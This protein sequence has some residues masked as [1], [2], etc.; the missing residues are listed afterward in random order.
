MGKDFGAILEQWEEQQAQAKKVQKGNQKSHKK[1]NAPTK[2]EKEAMQQGY[3]YEQQMQADN[4]CCANP[5]EVWLNRYG[6]V[7][8]DK[9]ADEA[10]EDALLHNPEYLKQ[11]R[12]EA[13]LDLHGLTR[14]DAWQRLGSFIDD[15][16]R[17]GFRKVTIIHG[18]GNHSHGT[19]PVLGPMVKLFIEQDKRL[20]RSGHPDRNNGGTGATWVLFK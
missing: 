17:R 4:A 13:T 19:D 14:D 7:D 9:I 3:S 5:L 15:C 16:E 10:R 20:G 2:E 12:S 8:K 1:A 11:L 6:T 18:K